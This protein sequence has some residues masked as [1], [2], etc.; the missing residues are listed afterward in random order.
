MS[1]QLYIEEQRNV[2]QFI[3]SLEEELEILRKSQIAAGWAQRN[4][5][6]AHVNADY[7]NPNFHPN[8]KFKKLI[9]VHNWQ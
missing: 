3:R 5:I 7:T 4:A 6:Y 2:A 1:D 9:L 8:P